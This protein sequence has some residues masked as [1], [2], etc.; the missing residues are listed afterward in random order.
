MPQPVKLSDDLIN[1][2]RDAAPTAHRSLAAQVE[3]WAALGR[4]IE[5]ALTVEQTVSLKRGVREP[6]APAYGTSATEIAAAVAKALSTAISAAGRAGV[7]N[8]LTSVGQAIYGSDPAF[9]GCIVRRNADG[10]MTPGH[11]RD[12]AFV[13]VES[14]A[15]PATNVRRLP[16]SRGGRARV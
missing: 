11:W 12:N 16:R 15:E 9:P 14:S 2:A 6:Q 5:G 13:A 4:S 3:H 1:A 8:E 10:S 7:R